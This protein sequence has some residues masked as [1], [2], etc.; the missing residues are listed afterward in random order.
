MLRARIARGALALLSIAVTGIGLWLTLARQ[1]VVWI[2]S[3][4]NPATS[5]SSIVDVQLVGVAL[6]CTGLLIS[7][8]ILICE[9]YLHPK[10]RPR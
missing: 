1:L 10:M 3:E 5:E 2:P 8:A 6:L 9:A 7:A 4:E